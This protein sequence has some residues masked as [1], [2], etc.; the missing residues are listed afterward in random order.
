L[1]TVPH[2]DDEEV[3]IDRVETA[4]RDA[5]QSMIAEAFRVMRT[6]LQFSAPQDRQRTLLITSPRPDDGKTTVAC[7]LAAALA[8]AGRRVLL[9]DANLRRPALH[10][11]FDK[12]G[13]VGLS[14]C[15][16]GETELDKVV[17]KTGL[18]NLDV[19]G[20]GPTPPNPAE[21]LNGALARRFLDQALARYDQ[22]IIDTPP[23]L[24]AS[25][26]AV[27]ASMVDG[28]ILVFRAKDNSRGQAQ[29]AVNL[30]DRVNAYLFGG[31]LNG[32]QV[33]RGGY[34]REQLRMFYEYQ[35]EEARNGR[36]PA[37]PVDGR[38]RAIA[39]SEERPSDMKSDSTES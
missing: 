18:V 22:I 11:V 21:L 39:H 27:L 38:D 10:T 30:L 7:N 31:V 20:S 35:E 8:L 25:D 19:V 29:R 32:A 12:V 16:V 37:L 28:V 6:N 14:N 26:A 36:A 2:S 33:R 5:P 23:V 1:G 9:V 13:P 34:F 15:L 24:L 3:N 4:V 17:A